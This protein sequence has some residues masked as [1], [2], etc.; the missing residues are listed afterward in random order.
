MEKMDDILNWAAEKLPPHY[1]VYIGVEKD[2]G[3]VTV[4]TPQQTID[5][6]PG[7]DLPMSQHVKDAVN[8][9]RDEKIKED[10]SK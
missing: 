5:W 3:W 7:D 8:W 2:A 4:E 6:E 1:Q 10:E 9:C